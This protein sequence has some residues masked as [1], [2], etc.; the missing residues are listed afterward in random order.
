MCIR[1]RRREA[2]TVEARMME[3]WWKVSLGFECE[4]VGSSAEVTEARKFKV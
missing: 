4:E 3:V 1:D 2:T